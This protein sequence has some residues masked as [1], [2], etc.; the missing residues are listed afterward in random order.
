VKILLDE[1]FPLDFRHSFP[2]HDVHTVQWAGFKGKKN[3]ELVRA[4]DD[5]GYDALLTI[6]KNLPH[7]QSLVDLRLSII[8][9]AA[10]TNQLEDLLPLANQIVEALETL[11]RG[12]VIRVPESE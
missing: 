10:P 7:Q 6:D 1:C 12:A 5:A 9:V 3:G 2:E 8:I 11:K 4:A